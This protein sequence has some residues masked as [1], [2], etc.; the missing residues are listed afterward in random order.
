MSETPKLPQ[1]LPPDPQSL[2]SKQELNA[3][4]KWSLG[5]A[6]GSLAV[7]GA[8]VYATY[9]VATGKNPDLAP[10]AAG[11]GTFLGSAGAALNL[12]PQTVSL[13]KRRNSLEEVGSDEK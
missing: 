10:L 11:S 7:A 4:I 1:D 5:F 3:D 8:S 13:I 2:L 12:I 6:I 9:G